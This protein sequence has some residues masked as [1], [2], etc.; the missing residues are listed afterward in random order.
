MFNDA[1]IKVDHITFGGKYYIYEKGIP[2]S[3]YDIS[4][5]KSTFGDFYFS[6]CPIQRLEYYNQYVISIIVGVYELDSNN[7]LR[8]IDIRNNKGGNVKVFYI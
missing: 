8:V 7:L 3:A 1:S 4:T 5:D 6:I 2:V